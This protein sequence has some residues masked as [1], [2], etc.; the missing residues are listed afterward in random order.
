ML[1]Y[2]ICDTAW[3]AS[4]WL[5]RREEGGSTSDNGVYFGKEAGSSRLQVTIL[6]TTCLT[7]FTLLMVLMHHKKG[8]WWE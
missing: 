2:E 8:H 7:T 4:S 6:L 1:E 3:G 5:G